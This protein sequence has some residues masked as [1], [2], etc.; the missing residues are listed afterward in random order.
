MCIHV[1]PFIWNLI[2]FVADNQEEELR[3]SDM[4]GHDEPPEA[5]YEEGNKSNLLLI[6]FLVC[7]SS[8]T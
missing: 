6:K 7:V 4:K 2:I 3:S 1:K 5:I 8:K